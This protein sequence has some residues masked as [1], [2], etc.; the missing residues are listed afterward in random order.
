[1]PR[2]ANKEAVKSLLEPVHQRLKSYEEQVAR[3]RS[4]ARSM[5]SASSPA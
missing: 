1:M 5:R 4:Q 3:A 2:Q